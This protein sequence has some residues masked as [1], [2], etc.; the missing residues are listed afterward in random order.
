MAKHISNQTKALTKENSSELHTT[1]LE[2]HSDKWRRVG[3]N[4]HHWPPTHM[5][6]TTVVSGWKL[7]KGY[8]GS[9]AATEKGVNYDSLFAK[10]A[11][12]PRQTVPHPQLRFRAKSVHPRWHLHAMSYACNGD[13][14]QT[15]VRRETQSTLWSSFRLFRSPVQQ[16]FIFISYT[17]TLHITTWPASSAAHLPRI[18]NSNVTAFYF[19]SYVFFLF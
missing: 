6:P 4:L 2:D 13:G 18:H 8:E 11:N 5:T 19:A 16:P 9:M 17:H 1:S 3:E 7:S 10:R 15:Y 12:G 14:S